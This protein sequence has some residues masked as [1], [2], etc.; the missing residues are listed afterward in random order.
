LS[1]VSMV[2]LCLY[3]G[4]RI[5]QLCFFESATTALPYA[6]KT[7]SKYSGKPSVATS[8]FFRDPEYARLRSATQ[9][10]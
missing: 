7:Y 8:A 3:P 6:D 2:P 5:S 9:V 1:N 4:V 10:S